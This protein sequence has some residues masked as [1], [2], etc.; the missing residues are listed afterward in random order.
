MARLQ[1]LSVFR[2]LLLP[3]H[4]TSNPPANPVAQLSKQIRNL[5]PSPHLL[6]CPWS[7]PP[8]PPPWTPA[9]V[10]HCASSSCLGPASVCSVC[11][12]RGAPFKTTS[13]CVTRGVTPPRLRH[14]HS[15]RQSP[16][17]DLHDLAVN[18]APLTHSSAATLASFQIHESTCAH[19]DHRTLAPAAASSPKLPWPIPSP[20]PKSLSNCHLLR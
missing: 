7:E 5:P 17:C 14:P 10:P 3:S 20:L 19:S 1:T 13:D 2:T 18:S 4:S 16:S 15:I 11:G 9:G 8:P 6:R 12:N